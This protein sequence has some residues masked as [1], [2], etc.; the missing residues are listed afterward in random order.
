MFCLTTFLYIVRNV[1]SYLKILRAFFELEILGCWG[2][3][4]EALKMDA[5]TFMVFSKRIFEAD[6]LKVNIT[7]TD[8]LYFTSSR[9]GE[10]FTTNIKSNIFGNILEIIV[11]EN[12]S[13]KQQIE[14]VGKKLA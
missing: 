4:V 14:H 7:K 2:K 13:W 12:L 5:C 9:L 8:L 6:N 10:Q 11:D 3:S 1:G